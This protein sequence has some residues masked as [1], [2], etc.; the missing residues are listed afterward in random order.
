MNLHLIFRNPMIEGPFLEKAVSVVRDD[1]IRVDSISDLVEVCENLCSKGDRIGILE[2]WGHSNWGGRSG[3]S[4][5]MDVGRDTL[6]ESSVLYQHRATLSRLNPLFSR[7]PLAQVFLG[8]C[9]LGHGRGLLQNLSRI[10]GGVAVMAG[11]GLQNPLFGGVEGGAQVCIEMTC[12][13]VR[14]RGV[15]PSGR[16][17]LTVGYPM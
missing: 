8:G 2:H 6:N 17:D 7:D 3:V 12:H 10:W 1:L 16:M 14:P 11:Y 5:S 13:D 15:A 4:Y 9:W